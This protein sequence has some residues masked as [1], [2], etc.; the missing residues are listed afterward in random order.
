MTHQAPHPTVA[1]LTRNPLKPSLYSQE[2]YFREAF[3]DLE[4]LL[5]ERTV[6]TV[7][8][9][10]LVV[11]KPD[12]FALGTTGTVVD[13]YTRHGFE[14]VDIRPVA[15]TPTV[16]R[17]LWAYQMTQASIDRLLVNDLVIDGSAVALLFRSRTDSPL[18]TA[19]RLSALKGPA[20]MEKQDE[21]CLRRA[22][23]QPNRIF[24]L[25]HSAD[26]P[27]DFVRELGILFSQRDRRAMASAMASGIP[28][29]Q[30]VRFLDEV[31]LSDER[32]LRTFDRET[33]R[34]RVIDAIGERIAHGST[35]T[36][37]QD[38][39]LRAVEDLEAGRILQA[40]KLFGALFDAE[41]QV[42]SWDLAVT[43]SE[44]IEDDVPGASKVIDNFGT[45]A[46]EPT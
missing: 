1:P 2:P 10:G 17:S 13:F 11:V 6:D 39:L 8:R 45:S 9:H 18:P 24:S 16:W 12:G 33:S 7:M 34:K 5:G 32:P 3:V 31:R 41:V 15:F 29:A 43:V 23:G 21:D 35:P 25:V 28:S 22:I 46:W 44:V 26:E 14:P 37:Q 42:D 38:R 4:A 40:S 36:A 20:R 30:S 19:V 27:A